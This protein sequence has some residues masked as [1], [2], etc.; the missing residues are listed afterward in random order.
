MQETIEKEVFVC[1]I[2]PSELVAVNCVCY[3]E[4][5]CHR[6]PMCEQAVLRFL[7][8]LIET[9]LNQGFLRVLKKY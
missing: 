6:Q 2:I 8:T 7:I 5:T 1:Y 9:F 3:K 4:T